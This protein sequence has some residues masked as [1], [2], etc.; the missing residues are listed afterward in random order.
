[1]SGDEAAA[2]EAS[3]TT[4][5]QVEGVT[6][7]HLQLLKRTANQ[8]HQHIAVWVL[9]GLILEAK[10]STNCSMSHERVGSLIEGVGLLT[11]ALSRPPSKDQGVLTR[12]MVSEL[13]KLLPCVLQ[14][15][16]CSVT[17]HEPCLQN[18]LSDVICSV[19][20]VQ[21]GCCSWA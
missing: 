7:E 9:E 8:Q 3:T 10:P 19:Q 13:V 6:V 16:V 12:Y 20:P 2:V 17:L 11:R 5:R 15:L 14:E 4:L 21:T 1:M 18:A